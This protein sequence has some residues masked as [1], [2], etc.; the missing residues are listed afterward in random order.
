MEETSL[1]EL[2]NK[3]LE[4]ARDRLEVA[5]LLFKEGKHVDA[6]NR[7]YYA[8]FHAGKAL[9][10]SIGRDTKTHAGLVSE[11]GFHLVEKGIVEKKYG[12]ILRR[13]FESRETSDYVI[14][15]VFIEEEVKKMI[16]DAQSF[17]QMAE[18][19]SR[20]NIKKYQK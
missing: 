15:A 17:I 8:V 9:I 1:K 2:I 12:T 7:T 6:V 3:E 11:I 4:T 13:L 5:E 19:I 18:K 16:E 20:K 14:G 10:H